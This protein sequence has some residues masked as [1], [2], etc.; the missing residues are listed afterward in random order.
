MATAEDI[1]SEIE[2]G[3]NHLMGPPLLGDLIGLDVVLNIMETLNNGFDNPRYR[4]SPLLKHMV[5]AGFWVW[6]TPT[7]QRTGCWAYA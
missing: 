5:S 2:L 1:D 4:P 6:L 3:A 7:R